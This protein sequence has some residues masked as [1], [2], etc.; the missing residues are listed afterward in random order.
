MCSVSG[1]RY[2]LISGDRWICCT[3]VV[4]VYVENCRISYLYDKLYD[5]KS[6]LPKKYVYTNVYPWNCY[7]ILH[8][9]RLLTVEH[10]ISL[11]YLVPLR[12]KV[13]FE[14][15]RVLRKLILKKKHFIE[16]CTKLVL[17]LPV[18]FEGEVSCYFHLFVS[19]Q[20][21]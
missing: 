11:P 9:I 2:K 15:S 18:H 17:V 3:N 14:L 8:S 7:G 5:E 16:C 19:T 1:G 13:L 20:Q 12:Y 6:D 4:V 21:F 10:C